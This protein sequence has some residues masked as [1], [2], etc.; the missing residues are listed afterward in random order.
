[1]TYKEL[2]ICRD[3]SVWA[4]HPQGCCNCLKSNKG[5]MIDCKDSVQ[6]LITLSPGWHW[7]LMHRKFLMLLIWS[8]DTFIH[9][10]CPL[11]NNILLKFS[12]SSLP[13]SVQAILSISVSIQCTVSTS[14]KAKA[15]S[16]FLTPVSFSLSIGDPLDEPL[17]APNIKWSSSAFPFLCHPH[18]HTHTM[19]QLSDSH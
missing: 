14:Q 4:V 7:Q 17:S 11:S 10:L 2:W 8:T 16:F 3:S 9:M 12:V 5:L 13:F 19:I 18:T 15:L 6:M 1:M